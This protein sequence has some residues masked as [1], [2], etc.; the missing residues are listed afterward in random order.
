MKSHSHP[1][2]YKRIRNEMEMY[3]EGSRVDG[4]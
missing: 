3:L 4:T 2:R 1:E